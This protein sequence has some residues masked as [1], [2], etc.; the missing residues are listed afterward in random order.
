MYE[1]N[2]EDGNENFK[3]DSVRI[4]CEELASEVEREVRQEE[5]RD[6]EL[7]N[8]AEAFKD[9][10]WMKAM[11]EELKAIKD[12]NTWSLVELPQGKNEIDVKWV[13]KVKLNPKGGVTRHRARLMGKGFLHKEGIDFDEFFS[14]VVRIKIIRLVISLANM[15]NWHVS[16]VD[17]KCA[18]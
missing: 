10:K 1:L 15:N 12:N 18:F 6:V 16:H 3:K 4:L 9:S 11:N 5:V 2:E 14:P 13:Y 7:V 8:A 17:V